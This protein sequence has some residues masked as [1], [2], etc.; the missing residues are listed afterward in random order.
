MMKT[1][2]RFALLYILALTISCETEE[3]KNDALLAEESHDTVTMRDLD[4]LPAS[5]TQLFKGKSQ[6][7]SNKALRSETTSFGE[8]EADGVFVQQNAATQATS[9]TARLTR[10]SNELYFDN[11]VIKETAEGD[12]VVNVLR[13]LPDLA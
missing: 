8:V 13:Y 4:E 2:Y 1:I 11:M 9:Y 10:L 3:L 6:V 7:F 12:M 5:I